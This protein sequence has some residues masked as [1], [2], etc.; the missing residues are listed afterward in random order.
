MIPFFDFH[1]D[2]LTKG[3]AKEL[4]TGEK[5]HWSLPRFKKAGGKLQV[6]AI[7]TPP[8]YK[9]GDATLFGMKYASEWKYFLEDSE[10]SAVKTVDD[11]SKQ[12]PLSLLSLE[13]ASP[14][15]GNLETLD[16]FFD[17]GIRLITLVWSCDNE[18][19][20]GVIN[21]KGPPITKFGRNLIKKMNEKD[22]IIDVSHASDDLFWE[23]VNLSSKPIV[24]SHSNS[25]KLRNHPRNLTDE[26]IK[27]IQQHNGIIGL[28]YV[29][30]FVGAPPP[31]TKDEWNFE[32]KNGMDLLAQH[33]AHIAEISSCENIVL[34]SDFD[35]T[36]F[37]VVEEVSKTQNLISSLEK[38]GFNNEEIEKIF[39]KNAENFLMNNLPKN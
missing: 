15:S 27:E 33:A 4:L 22:I 21:G 2:S 12:G 5:M 6:H 10:V 37:P 8:E 20:R 35:G 26:Q 13:D 32:L 3:G 25:R 9:K 28:V 34:G 31:G 38:V 19:G 11:V 16:I 17:L 36:S 29:P 18:V 7:F 1:C 24:A 39:Y 14:L 30:N 23:T